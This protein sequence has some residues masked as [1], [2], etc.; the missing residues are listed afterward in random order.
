MQRRGVPFTGFV[1]TTG[2]TTADANGNYDFS[3]A[4][5]VLNGTV[6]TNPYSGSPFS[7]FLE[8]HLPNQYFRM[9]AK[10]RAVLHVP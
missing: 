4:P 2:M 6:L 1:P 3:G 7:S 8:R 10:L 9:V 5:T